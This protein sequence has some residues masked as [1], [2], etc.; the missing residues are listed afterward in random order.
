MIT[1]PQEMR[2]LSKRFFGNKIID[3]IVLEEMK[4]QYQNKERIAS[5]IQRCYPESYKLYSDLDPQLL[6]I[7]V[8]Y[9][10]NQLNFVIEKKYIFQR[11]TCLL[12]LS[13]H[14]FN[15]SW[16]KRWNREKSFEEFKQIIVRHSLYRPPH[17]VYIFSLENLKEISS[18]FLSTFF[19]FYRAY[20]FTFT[21]WVDIVVT[22]YQ[23]HQIKKDVKDLELEK[24]RQEAEQYNDQIDPEMMEQLM[25]GNSIY[26]IPEKKKRE[27]LEQQQQKEKQERI[28]RVLKKRLEEL[29][30]V[31]DQ[32]IKEQDEH[33]I[34]LAEDLKNP[35]KK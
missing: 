35:K 23:K 1:S 9:F 8:Q 24:L 10:L 30:Q 28:D 21:P 6:S 4:E 2:I 19:R 12:E 5:I 31:F 20:F 13:V 22:T 14:L 15:I 27:M 25:S 34:K 7:F 3:S 33:F 32:K 11:A 17:N 16:E 29:Q 18:H 26:Q